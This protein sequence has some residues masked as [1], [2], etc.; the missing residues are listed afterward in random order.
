MHGTRQV[1]AWLS[2]ATE[3]GMTLFGPTENWQAVLIAASCVLSDESSL[4][5]YSACLGKPL[6]LAAARGAT[7]VP[8]S[9]ADR[10][11]EVSPRLRH[12]VDLLA[13]VEHAM[14]CHQ[15]EMLEP[16]V[17]RAVAHPGGCAALL[18]PLLYRM[19]RLPAPEVVTEF[20]AIP[21]PQH[22]PRSPSAY[23]AGVQPGDAR[24]VVRFPASDTAR[25]QVDY[26]HL[27]ADL[28][29]ASM[30]QLAS[31]KVLYVTNQQRPDLVAAL[32]AW[33]DAVLAGYRVDADSCAVATRDGV[34][35]TLR[36]SEGGHGIDPL[37]LASV[38]YL[39]HCRGQ[40]L[41]GRTAVRV[42]DRLI[43]VELRVE[44][45]C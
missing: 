29:R 35:A 34:L 13:Q 42:G 21:E 6:L 24:A 19:L 12:D 10:L 16:V 27:A 7:T 38:G 3:A 15:P 39:R 40:P 33:P 23:L 14:R 36:I 30:R 26:P 4:G 8:G 28:R 32:T 9:P 2:R 1:R 44:G 41:S 45:A 25:R 43:A 31:A 37:L 17:R 5:L 20:A 18:V 11:P 22:N